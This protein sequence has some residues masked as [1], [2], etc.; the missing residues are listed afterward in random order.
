VY[1]W[2][3]GGGGKA[4]ITLTISGKKEKRRRAESGAL[5]AKTPRTV[6]RKSGWGKV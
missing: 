2:E 6:I 4:R 1:G 3:G 5:R